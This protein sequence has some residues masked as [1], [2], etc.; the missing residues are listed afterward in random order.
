MTK[1]SADAKITRVDGIDPALLR[2]QNLLGN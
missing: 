2:D 1:I